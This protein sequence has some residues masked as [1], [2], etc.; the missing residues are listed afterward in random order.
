M[1]KPF[2]RPAEPGR[3]CAWTAALLAL[4]AAL[5]GALIYG[6]FIF[7]HAVPLGFDESYMV[8]LA[9]RLIDG[10]FVP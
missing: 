9:E 3:A 1:T 8:P 7:P 5:V 4:S 2:Q 10:H 6:R